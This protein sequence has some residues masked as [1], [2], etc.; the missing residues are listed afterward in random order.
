MT[1]LVK[2][3]VCSKTIQESKMILR[4]L[5]TAI[6]EQNWFTVALEIL[7]VVVGV[8]VGLQADQWNQSRKDRL[9]EQQYLTSLKA[10]FQVDIRE[11]D[12][13]IALAESRAQLG[14]LLHSAIQSGRVDTDPT[15]FVWAVYSSLLLNYPSYTRATVNDLLSTGNLQLIMDTELKSAI[16]E[17][18]TDIEYREQW[19]VNWRE[20]QIAMEHTMPYLLDFNIRESGLLRM[21][22]GPYWVTEEFSYELSDAEQVLRKVIEHPKAKG[23][24]ENMTRI[25][26]SH[27]L[28][29]NM[30]RDQA[31]ALVES[32]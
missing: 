19:I 20:M 6:R 30:I 5:A 9:V 16:A 1:G 13:A 31:V 7:I 11:L 12:E 17:Y 25:Q 27:Y 26:D 21:W 10:D 18:Y 4:R 15:E 8:F 32:L 22:D 24:I 28:N 2:H 23:Q 29:L 3:L 14:R